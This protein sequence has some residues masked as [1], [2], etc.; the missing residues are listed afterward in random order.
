MKL[1][2][3]PK[4]IKKISKMLS[5]HLR[6]HPEELHLDMNDQGWVETATLLSEF[7]KKYFELDRITL[8]YIVDNNSKKRFQFSEDEESIRANQGH[9]IKVD[10]DLE[11][12]NP[13]EYLYH[14]T[15]TKNLA[16]IMDKGI[17][18]GQRH[19]VHLSLDIPTAKAVGMRYGKPIILKVHAGK[20]TED[21]YPFFITEN[22]VWLTDHVP[23]NYIE[24]E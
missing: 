15:A 20:M 9:S 18:K 23:S 4:Q 17:I 3:D 2:M 5:Y 12:T 16:S 7:N 1:I 24:Y 19:H 21:G 22:K 6:H 8:K 14:G 13:P 11:P 10:L